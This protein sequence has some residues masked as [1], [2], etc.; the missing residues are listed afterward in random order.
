MIHLRSG[1][2]S[3]VL[4]VTDDRLPVVVHWGA[5]LGAV[6]GATL[7]ELRRACAPQPFG[8]P[9]DGAMPVSVL[10]EASSGWPGVRG[11]S[12]HRG[13]ASPSTRFVVTSVAEAPR[14][15]PWSAGVVV[16]AADDA[17]G[18]GLRLE[19]EQARSGL[20]RVRAVVTST[21]A[22]TY[23]LT[24]V[25]PALP[26]P[27]RAAELLD[28]TGHQL[29]ERSPQRLP[30]VH[31]TH[32]RGGA[33]GRPGFDS[34]FL[35]CAGEP[36]FG[37]R[38][39]EVWGVHAAWSG[40]Q[41]MLAQRTPH[42]VSLLA[43]GEALDPG[44]VRL[45]PGEAYTSPWAYGTYGVGLDDA[46][47][48]V[49]DW[50]RARPQHPRTPR[51][52]VVNT[53]EAV[54]FDHGTDRLRA[55]ADAAA[56]VGAERYVLDDGWFG[57]RRD[58]TAGLGDW[59]VSPEAHPDGL[60]P[61]VDHVHALGMDFGLWVE[62]EMVNL[63]SDVARA[64]PE[65][66]LTAAGGR[67]PREGRHQHVLNLA[68][69]GAYAHVRDQLDALL[70]RYPIACLKWDHN[71]EIGE[72]GLP[73]SGRGAVRAQTLAVH[74]LMDE[75]R[76]RHEGLEIETCASGGARVDLEMLQRTDRVWAS[77][78]TDA[79][80]R[81]GIQR[82]TSLLVPPEMIGA[83]VSAPVAPTS[84]RALP[85][86]FRC[87]VALFGHL[88]IEW[89]VTAALPQDRDRLAE[90]VA[91]YVRRRGLLHSGRVV[92]ADVAD[93]AYTLH[94]VVAPDG[95]EALYA[96]V[97]TASSESWPPPAQRLPGLDPD[98]TYRVALDGP[99]TTTEGVA[100]RWGVPVPWIE[101]GGVELPGRLL[102]EVGLALPV[103]FADRA[104]L[105]RVSAC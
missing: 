23:D 27:A 47:G 70:D 12:G 92:H 83:H 44:E 58:D 98:R 87:A 63:D 35:L 43:A 74:R 95:G 9:V 78:S 68:D 90:W 18:L 55:L 39:G 77:D 6:D 59:V 96:W 101:A 22:G 93:P 105:L 5:D 11:V 41:R 10:P 8:Y 72:A 89:D 49:H 4:A 2:V 48:R 52:V 62:P 40:N 53:W 60:G 25:L 97:C 37:A 54:T 73:P 42:G 86:D 26:V 61:L 17:A 28:L 100:A 1:G 79:H 29:R 56:E 30:F 104:V 81:V 46:A 75:L 34:A 51:P 80:E 16:D 94:G 82:W 66:I 64:H 65:W 31:G 71:R 20:V 19:V 24:G 84:D 103:L 38:S 15:A 88:G 50:L 99:I 45:G 102:G 67:P 13:G 91:Y 21:G 85:L 14:P 57:A 7:A 69:P 32:E 36:G 76:E 3:L 33:R